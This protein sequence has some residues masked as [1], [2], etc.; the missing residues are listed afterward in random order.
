MVRSYCGKRYGPVE[1]GTGF[2]LGAAFGYFAAFIIYGVLPAEIVAAAVFGIVGAR[3]YVGFLVKRRKKEFTLE[4]CDYLD[5]ISSSLSCG[6]NAY[7]AF[8]IA[9]EDMHGLYSASSPIC[10]ESLRISNGLRSGRG[11]DELLRFMAMRSKSED[12]EIFA[13][14]FS[15]CNTAGGNLRQTVNETKATITEKINMEN[16]IKSSLAAPKNE[17]NIMAA[18]PIAITAALRVLGDSIVGENTFFVNTVA[19]CLFIGAYYLGLRMVRI[20]V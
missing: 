8:I 19:V 20:E 9:D 14:V 16:E 3:I 17:L 10:I 18:M 7:E 6:K 2:L 4:F 13:D 11:I 1:Y 5:A 15:I 12:V